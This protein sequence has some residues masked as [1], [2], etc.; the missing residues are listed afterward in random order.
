MKIR[1]YLALMV[2][3][4]LIPV[5]LFSTISLNMLL[6]SERDAALKGVRETARISLVSIDREL[7]NTESAL[8]MLANSPYLASGDMAGFYQQAHFAD[9]PGTTWTALLNDKGELLMNT[10]VP[11]GTPMPPGDGAARVAQ[12]LASGKP[13]VSNLIRGVVTQALLVVVDLPVKTPDGTRYVISQGFKIQ[14]FN[15][16]LR[17]VNAPSGWLAG[18]FDRNGITIAHTHGKDGEAPGDAQPDLRDAIRSKTV[19]VIRNASEDRLKLYTVLE[20]SALSGWTVAVGVPEAEIES[21]ARQALMVSMFGLLAAVACA[22]GAALFFARRLSHSIAQAARSA[23]ALEHDQELGPSEVSGV[24]EVDEV[25]DAIVAAAAVV[26][27]EKASRQVAEEEREIL[28]EREHQA[29]TVAEQQN[30]AKDEF[31]AMLGHELRNPLAAIVNATGVMAHSAGGA[32]AN[33]RARD[34]IARQSGHLTRI[35]DDLLDM[36]RVHSGKILLERRALRLDAAVDNY[37]AAVTESERGGRHAISVASEPVWVDA[38]PTRLEQII[39]NLIDNALK[40]T[41]P[42]GSINVAVRIEGA[43]AVLAVADSGIGISQELMPFVF[44]LFV[45]GT[46]TLDRAQGGLGVGLALVRQLALMHGGRVTVYSQGTGQGSCFELRLPA[47]AAPPAQEPAV[48]PAAGARQHVLLIEDN[49]DGREMMVLMLESNAY[50]VSSAADGYDGLRQAL[51]V[52]PDVALV[53]IGLPGID[54][55]EVA[56]RMRAD[57]ATRAV[58]LVALTGYGQENDRATA[59]DAG[60]DAHL[61]KPVEMA[62]LVRVL[63]ELA[64]SKAS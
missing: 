50:Q 15:G 8:R 28:F 4:I 19:G 42:G 39:A 64:P 24:I 26:R 58:R 43:E 59:L 10:A 32:E 13:Q 16:V 36:G 2:A 14:H 46:R 23:H 41:P 3:A 34:I 30:R 25:Q 53:D 55:Y 35:I 40:Y 9:R 62:R 56:R 5:I 57:P 20:R 29:R 1:T 60:F 17:N 45:Q 52:Q 63:E 27:M 21:A 11:F 18:V 54:G 6:K 33:A 47:V 38:D 7:T 61:V 22:A 51:A 48:S 37:M 49:E 31:L 12:V 44:D